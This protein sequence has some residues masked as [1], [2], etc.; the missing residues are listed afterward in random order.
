MCPDRPVDE[1]VSNPVAAQ[2][3]EK[4]GER[5]DKQLQAVEMELR[6]QSVHLRNV[7]SCEVNPR[8]GL[9]E[10]VHHLVAALVHKPIFCNGSKN[11]K[12]HFNSILFSLC[13]IC[14]FGL[15]STLFGLC[16]PSV[17]YS[18]SGVQTHSMSML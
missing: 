18:N 13:S 14:F 1:N 17:V 6:I 12:T 4:S 11:L 9:T 8:V 5:G 7:L 16:F 2:V 15:C 3:F 10:E